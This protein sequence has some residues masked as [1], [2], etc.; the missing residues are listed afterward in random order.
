MARMP[1]RLTIGELSRRSGVAASALRFYESVG[2][3]ASERTIGNQPFAKAKRHRS[4]AANPPARHFR[5]RHGRWQPPAQ[6]GRRIVTK[7]ARGELPSQG[8]RYEV[9]SVA[10]TGR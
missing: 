6:K 1:A 7:Y 4:S 8:S 3:V 9:V 10:A 5:A 2:L